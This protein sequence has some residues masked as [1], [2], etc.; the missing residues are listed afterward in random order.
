MGDDRGSGREGVMGEEQVVM[1][2]YTVGGREDH[3]EWIPDYMREGMMNWIE[4]GVL[5]GGFLTAI[6]SND[7][8]GACN[9]ADETNS[10]NLMN[11]AKFLYNAAPTGSFGG[12]KEVREW[13]DKG[14]LIGRV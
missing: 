2:V 7:F 11:Y 4:R 5:P 6:L 14:G 13:H 3:W 9:K 10:R 12:V 1:P 8:M